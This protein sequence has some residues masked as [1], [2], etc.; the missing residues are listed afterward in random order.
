[1]VEYG[2]L[3]FGGAD[4]LSGFGE[5][6]FILVP[7]LWN[8]GVYFWPDL[9]SVPQPGLLGNVFLAPVG[10]VVGGGSAETGMC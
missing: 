2:P 9:L 3:G 4:G 5:E 1:V 8:P 6:D 7:G 10:R